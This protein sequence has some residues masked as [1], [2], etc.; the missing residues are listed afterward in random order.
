MTSAAT[1][2]TQAE[3]IEGIRNNASLLYRT[4]NTEAIKGPNDAIIILE[5]MGDIRKATAFNWGRFLYFAV[6]PEN[7]TPAD[8]TFLNTVAARIT[9]MLLMGFTLS[10]SLTTYVTISELTLDLFMYN[11][12]DA[13]DTEQLVRDYLDFITDPLQGAGYGVGLDI[14]KLS[15]EIKETVPGTSNLIVSS[16]NSAAP[17]NINLTALQIFNKINQGVVTINITKVS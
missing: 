3:Q 16:V 9:N 17:A 12:F 11:E 13:T 14:G 15:Q 6:I 7:G 4:K 5:A 2:G 1:G 10:P 8:M